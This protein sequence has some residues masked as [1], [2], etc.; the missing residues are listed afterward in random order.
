MVSSDFQYIKYEK[1]FYPLIPVRIARSET[2]LEIHTL[3]DSGAVISIFKSEVADYLGIPIDRGERR[4]STG[5]SGPITVYIHNLKLQV[6]D[7][8]FE[9]KIAFSRQL[10]S[11]F[12]ILGRDGFFDRHTITFDEKIKKITITEAD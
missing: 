7:K 5:I 3:I 8:E 1:F 10:K 4:T 9:C 12:N 2:S 11:R 6:F